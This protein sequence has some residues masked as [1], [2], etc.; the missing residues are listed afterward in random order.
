MND[1]LPRGRF[2]EFNYEEA[3]GFMSEDFSVAVETNV[4]DMEDNSR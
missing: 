2:V 4:P 3:L 1:I